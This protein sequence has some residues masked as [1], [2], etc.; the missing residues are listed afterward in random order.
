[1]GAGYLYI[2]EK[3]MREFIIVKVSGRTVLSSSDVHNCVMETL[4]SVLNESLL[5]RDLIAESIL[6][7]LIKNQS[8]A[9]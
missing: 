1:M 9:G 6:M 8:I 7:A 3:A 2:M 5:S 4:T